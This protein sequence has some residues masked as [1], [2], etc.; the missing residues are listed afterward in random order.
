MTHDNNQEE[1]KKASGSHNC[2]ICH[3]LL[4]ATFQ[5]SFECEISRIFIA[6]KSGNN[7]PVQVDR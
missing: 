3:I 4:D 2:I 1:S 7:R 5:P 6:L